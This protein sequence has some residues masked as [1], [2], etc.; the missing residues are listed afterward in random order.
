MDYSDFSILIGRLERQA[1]DRPQLYAAKV[2]LVAV[3]GYLALAVLALA[4]LAICFLIVDS[5]IEK[6]RPSG[7]MVLAGVAAISTLAALIRALW[8]RIDEPEGRLLTPEEAPQLFARIDDIAARMGGVPIASVTINSEFNASISQIPRWGVFG[9]YRNHLQLG[10]PLLAALSVEEFTAVLAHEMGH[11]SE[12][13]GKFGAWIYRQRVTWHALERKLAEPSNVFQQALAAFYQWYAPYF[14]AYSFVLGRAQE[15]AADRAAAQITQPLIV[16]RA[17]TKVQLMSRFLG[18]VFWERFFAHIEK[19]PEPPYRPFSIMP[20]AFKVAEKE[21]SR[22]DWLRESLSRYA[23]DDDT[24]PS[25]AERLA[26][27]DLTPALPAYGEGPSA[28]TLLGPTAQA[29]IHHCDEEWREE[30]L[31]SWKKRHEGVREARWKIAEYEK[32]ELSQL[33][34]QDLW[35]KAELLFSVNRYTEGVGALQALVARDGKFPKAHL[36]LGQLLLE[37]GEERGLEHLVCVAKQDAEL[38][39]T[40]GAVGY[41]YLVNRGRKGEAQRF[42]ERIST[43][44]EG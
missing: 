3:L 11:L 29:L 8:V 15:Y 42:W 4:I 19:S 6:G 33:A 16:G 37:Q 35:A 7:W 26:A 21:W 43:A 31:S 10:V 13:H 28:L 39:R 2:A 44:V 1:D 23:A 18:E 40:A 38:A 9:N 32:Y 12:Q 27:L 34:P 24:H 25:L 14:Y 30:N 22:Q 36:M 20:R 17:L 41:T 5:I